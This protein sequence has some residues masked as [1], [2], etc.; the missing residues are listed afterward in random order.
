MGIK[1]IF[2]FIFS[3][4]KSESG[5]I[6]S[7]D[8]KQY[9]SLKYALIY[10]KNEPV[11]E[12]TDFDVYTRVYKKITF[13]NALIYNETSF[14]LD[15]FKYENLKKLILDKNLEATDEFIL[16][17]AF[18]NKNENTIK[19]CKEI[20]GSS[21]N[22]FTQGLVYDEDKVTLDYYISVPDYLERMNEAYC[23]D[24]Y[25]DFAAIDPTRD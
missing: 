25:F 5:V 17:I 12:S 2:S 4:K 22:G 13:V 24:I 19:F 23:E 1:D 21:K 14:N 11:V 8:V 20:R 10:A 16:L 7:Y 6:G 18:Q 9:H 3:K 15:F